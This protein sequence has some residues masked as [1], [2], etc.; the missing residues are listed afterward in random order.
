MR[1][2]VISEQPLYQDEWLDI[3]MSDI[4]LPDGRRL[5]HRSI[6]TPPGAGVV[7]VDDRQRVLLIWRHR[8]IP[9]SWGWEIPIGKI[10]DGETPVQAAAREFEEET[11]WRPG[12]LRP[13]LI[14]RPT[15][16]LS[17]S[18]HHI[19]QA[20]IATHVGDPIDGFES[21]RIEWVPLADIRALIGTGQ[22][23]SATTQASLLYALTDRPAPTDQP[24]LSS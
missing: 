11:G 1:W 15:P 20:D 4:E 22:I 23:T 21:E 5:L 9:D 8:Y 13:Q 18:E 12:P 24:R 10:E 16:G 6:H 3:R 19:Y 2:K 7:A 17:N 14:V